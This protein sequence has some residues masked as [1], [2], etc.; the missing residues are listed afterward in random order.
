M[1]RISTMLLT[2]L[3]FVGFAVFPIPSHAAEF[4]GVWVDAFHPG[5]MGPE[6]TTEMVERAKDANFNALFIQVRKRGDAY[7]VSGIEPRAT[8]IASD[9]DALADVIQKA[10]TAGLE[11]HAWVSVLDIFA[12]SKFY[13]ASADHIIAKHPEWLMCT[14]DGS[15]SLDAGKL[16]LDPGIPAVQ[17]YTLAVIMD[18]VKR[19]DVDGIHLDNIRYLGSNTGYNAISTESF[20]AENKTTGTPDE[21][22]AKWCAWRR[23]QVTS[24]V[25][26]IYRAVT[27]AKPSVKV[28]AS[29][30]AN[31][32]IAYDEFFQDWDGWLNEGILDFAVP[33]VFALDDATFEKTVDD[34]LTCAHSRQVYIGQGAWRLPIEQTQ[35]QLDY[36]R[37]KDAP[38]LVIFSYDYAT[39]S[40]TE[41]EQNL[42]D[43]LR[44]STFASTEDVPLLPWKPA[45]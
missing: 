27:T 36:V 2:G 9:Y 44:T 33:M 25:R 17:K 4:R 6:Q 41:G 20:N 11:V 8:N 40:K 18:I 29:V 34:V 19:Y 24:L 3:L 14:K 28:S 32:S 35:K 21:K 7:Y 23:D 5:F 26:D 43:A 39:R 16:M 37:S 12:N 13:Q 10:H 15:T 42:L 1:K 38:G 31:R 45:K 22:D 30:F